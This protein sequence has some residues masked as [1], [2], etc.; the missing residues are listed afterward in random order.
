MIMMIIKVRMSGSKIGAAHRII[1]SL[2]LNVEITC[3]WGGKVKVKVIITHLC[4]HCDHNFHPGLIVIMTMII[5]MIII[6]TM[7]ITTMII[8]T[9]ISRVADWC[10]TWLRA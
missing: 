5:M 1:L 10:A 8:M 4:H 6:M 2:Q 9:M 3:I 7:I